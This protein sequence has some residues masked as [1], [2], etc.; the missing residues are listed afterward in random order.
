MTYIIQAAVRM[1]NQLTEEVRQI[2]TQGHTA[3]DLSLSVEV[4]GNASRKRQLELLC[5]FGEQ[6]DVF[7]CFSTHGCVKC[8]STDAWRTCR[9]LSYVGFCNI[10]EDVP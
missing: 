1:E 4:P 10:K 3:A 5:C 2:R 6:N 8:K 7:F 9:E